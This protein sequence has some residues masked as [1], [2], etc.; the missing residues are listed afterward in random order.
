MNELTPAPGR[1]LTPEQV[2]GG[3]DGCNDLLE[4]NSLVGRQ[5]VML[6]QFTIG[7]LGSHRHPG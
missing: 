7:Q 6:F 2:L 3:V 5:L 4:R 1:P